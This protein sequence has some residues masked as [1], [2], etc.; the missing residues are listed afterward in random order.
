MAYSGTPHR[1]RDDDDLWVYDLL[2]S[3]AGANDKIEITGLPSVFRIEHLISTWISGA[4]ATVQPLLSI[5]GNTTGVGVRMVVGAAA[6]EVDEQP[7]RPI[8]VHSPRGT[9]YVHNRVN[10]GSN[11]VIRGQLYI[12]PGAGA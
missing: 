12:R 11:N 6:A 10:S 7:P 9:L 4:G 2:E 1:V 3:D 8:L 5:D